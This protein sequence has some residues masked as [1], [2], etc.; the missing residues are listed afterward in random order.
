MEFDSDGILPFPLLLYLSSGRVVERYDSMFEIF[1]PILCPKLLLMILIWS[2]IVL[3]DLFFQRRSLQKKILENV[4]PY[5]KTMVFTWTCV[6]I[7]TK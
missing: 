3:K 7:Y 5:R 2:L 1:D 4:M 6:F